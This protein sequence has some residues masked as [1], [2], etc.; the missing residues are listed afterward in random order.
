[1]N[2]ILVVSEAMQKMVETAAIV[3]IAS[4]DHGLL[5]RTCNTIINL[6]HG[7]IAST[8]S[9]DAPTLHPLELREKRA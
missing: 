5:R 9:L 3:I 4:H 7:R 8:V 6:D 2:K 1:M